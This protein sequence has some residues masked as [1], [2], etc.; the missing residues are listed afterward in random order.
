MPRYEYRVVPAPRRPG[1]VRGKRTVEDRFAY[2]LSEAM[3]DLASEGWEYQRSETLRCEAKTGLFRTRTSEQT[4]LVFRR[5]LEDDVIG[6]VI[7]GSAPRP[8]TVRALRAHRG[9]GPAGSGDQTGT[10][11]PA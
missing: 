9:L 4:V 2:T 10:P 6:T 7:D 11:K 1:K 8:E 5:T 3:N